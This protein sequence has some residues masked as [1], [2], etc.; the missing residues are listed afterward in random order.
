MDYDSHIGGHTAHL[1]GFVIQANLLFSLIYAGV[2]SY[3]VNKKMKSRRKISAF[4]ILVFIIGFVIYAR[5]T[6]MFLIELERFAYGFFVPQ[7]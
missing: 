7:V 2:F 4:H 1:H 6:F 3:I 5:T